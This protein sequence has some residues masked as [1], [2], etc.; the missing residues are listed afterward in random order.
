MEFEARVAKIID[1][2]TFE[3]AGD[4]E[5]IQLAYVNASKL[6]AS[7]GSAAKRKLKKLICGKAVTIDPMG[8]EVYARTIANVKFGNYSVNEDMEL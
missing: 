2:G 4:S 7:G 5:R 3:T 8:R 6:S 1:S